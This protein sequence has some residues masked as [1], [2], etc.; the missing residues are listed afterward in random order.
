MEEKQLIDVSELPD[1][2]GTEK[3]IAWA[4]DIRNKF[5]E[6][7]LRYLKEEQEYIK[8]KEGTIQ[9]IRIRNYNKVLEV[10]NTFLLENENSKWWIEKARFNILHSIVSYAQYGHNDKK[11]TAQDIIEIYK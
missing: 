10:C 2:L 1:L 7:A 4:T 8:K 5:S 9:K 6:E 3:Q 11:L